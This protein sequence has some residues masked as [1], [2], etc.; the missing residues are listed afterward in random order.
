MNTLLKILLITSATLISSSA[1]AVKKVEP[2]VAVDNKNEILK[3]PTEFIQ[4][5]NYQLKITDGLIVL[6]TAGLFRVAILQNRQ[7]LLTNQLSEK[8]A[9]K[10]L[11]AYISVDNAEIT[12]IDGI[13]KFFIEYKNF[14]ITPAKN[15]RGQT[16]V[17]L[18]PQH[19]PESN[20]NLSEIL[21]NS[22]I[23]TTLGTNAALNMS[24]VIL[25]ATPELQQVKQKQ[26]KI[27]LIGCIYYQDCFGK[28]H[29]TNFAL[30]TKEYIASK[31]TWTISALK[32][33]NFAT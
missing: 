23:G 20:I 13:P 3:E 8:T 6:F 5:G 2:A 1:I 11:R 15:I 7:L 19:F 18:L 29:K 27:I 24:D 25:I 9:E 4:I 17:I 21:E 32:M 31:S 10:Q 14:G 16:K 30:Q 28:D 12:I 26:Q 22:S 33:G